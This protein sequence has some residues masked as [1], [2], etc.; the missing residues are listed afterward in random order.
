LSSPPEEVDGRGIRTDEEWNRL[1]TA[2]GALR[3]T[4]GDA[5]LQ[6]CAAAAG[7]GLSDFV[8]YTND[9]D[10]DVVKK[11]QHL[12]AAQWADRKPQLSRDSD[13]EHTWYKLLRN[14]AVQASTDDE[15]ISEWRRIGGQLGSAAFVDFV[16]LF[17][18]DEPANGAQDFA[19]E[20]WA[21]AITTRISRRPEG[22]GLVLV[23]ST[24]TNVT[25]QVI[26][27]LRRRA[28]VIANKFGGR[29]DGWGAALPG[30]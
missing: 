15:V 16:L 18:S 23:I 30:Q 17:D 19:R 12:L 9:S 25:A 11:W 5:K 28:E 24:E 20:H 26:A 4:V 2:I 21:G 27:T 6:W 1:L 8:F 10:V 22:D 29:F 14:E 13:P 3:E 7:E